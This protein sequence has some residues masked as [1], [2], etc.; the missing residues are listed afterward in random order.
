MTSP[1]MLAWSVPMVELQKQA[2]LFAP[3]LGASLAI[4]FGF[5]VG[6]SILSKLVL[7]IARRSDASKQDVIELLAQIGRVSLIIFGTVTALGTLGVNV[8]ALV[9]GLGLT[10]FALGFAFRDALSNILAGVMIVMYRPFL[11]E[12]HIAVVGLEGDV[13]GIDLRYT[14]LRHGDK[15]FLIPNSTLFTNPIILTHKKEEAATPALPF[16]IAQARSTIG[17]PVPSVRPTSTKVPPI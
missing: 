3:K 12:D 2:T 7:R 5:W 14:T 15:T 17:L 9:A 8:S 1:A 16:S 10:G 13:V 6:S 4:L 11:R